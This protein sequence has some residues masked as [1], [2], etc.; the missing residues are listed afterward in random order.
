M[1][2]K[3]AQKLPIR[4]VHVIALLI[5]NAWQVIRQV[6]YLNPNEKARQFRRM[7][8]WKPAQLSRTSTWASSNWC[9]TLQERFQRLRF[10][11]DH[12]LV[13]KSTYWVATAKIRFQMPLMALPETR[14]TALSLVIP[15][16]Q[17]KRRSKCPKKS[18][19]PSRKRCRW[20]Q[21][22]CSATSWWLIG[23]ILRKIRVESHSSKNL[24]PSIPSLAS[25]Q[26]K[27][28]LQRRP[29]RT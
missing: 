25:W 22:R 16:T 10:L 14:F 6:M 23:K 2:G 28:W 15:R 8:E 20:A 17:P 4:S 29:W 13:R 11:P 9:Q 19:L 21:T 5:N 27:L 7:V 26:A 18:S 1:L 12:L 3:E 24:L